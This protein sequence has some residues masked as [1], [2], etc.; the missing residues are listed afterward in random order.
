MPVSA[1]GA[2][3]VRRPAAHGPRAGRQSPCLWRSARRCNSHAAAPCRPQRKGFSRRFAPGA[4]RSAPLGRFGKA[5]IAGLR[6]LHLIARPRRAAKGGPSDRRAALRSC[7]QAQCQRCIPDGGLLARCPA[8]VPAQPPNDQAARQRRLAK[9]HFGFR[10]MHVHIHPLQDH[11]SSIQHRCGVAVA[12]QKIE[13]GHP[14]RAKQQAVQN[15]AAVDKQELLP[16]RTRA[17]RS[18]ARH[19][20]S[21]AS[22]RVRHRLPQEFSTNSRPS[23]RPAAPVQGIKQ[24]A[25]FPDRRGT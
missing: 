9:A 19:S 17:N 13:I 18:A 20:P 3:A 7:A 16:P 15:G 25:R 14:Q 1:I 12:R 6:G 21:A 23:T 22:R 24:I 8:A 11:R 4:V 10:R 5:C 2:S